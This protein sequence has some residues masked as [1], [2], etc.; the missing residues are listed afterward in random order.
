MLALTPSL[1]VLCVL[2]FGAEL[3][4]AANALEAGRGVGVVTLHG[5]LLGS[6]HPVVKKGVAVG[7]YGP[8]RDVAGLGSVQPW[9]KAKSPDPR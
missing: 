9:S 6:V 1:A 4:S 8:P 5:D 7:P 2:P 3:L